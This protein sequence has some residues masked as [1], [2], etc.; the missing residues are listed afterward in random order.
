MVV[1]YRADQV[2]S[3]LRP[4][5]V[6]EARAAYAEGRVELAQLREA[7][8]RAILDALEMQRQIGID[9]FTDGEM[10]RDAWMSTLADAVD[11]FIDEY[12]IRHWHKLDGS[13]ENEPSRAKI[14]AGKLRQVRRL[15]AHDASFL[16]QH[17]PGPFKITM[18]SPVT[19]SY[20]GYQA[21]VTDKVYPTREQL[22][23]T[24]VPI[25][26]SELQA[27]AREGVSYI[28][29]DEGFSGYVGEAWRGQLE[30]LGLEPAK[31]LEADIAAENACYDALPRDRIVLGIHICRGNSK[32]RWGRIGGYDWLAEQVFSSLNVDRFLL[33]Y[34]SDRAG[35]FEPLRF[36]PKGKI[37]VLG[38]VTTKHGQPEP[39]DE[40][41]RQIDRA[42]KYLPLDQL[43][44]SPQCGFASVSEGNLLSVDDQHRKLEL[45]VD[46]ARKVWG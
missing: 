22:L 27:L 23:D 41:M 1:P 8:D 29:L 43:A 12:Q 18:P 13:T 15:T 46:T 14:A 9:I 2:G 36:V 7:E 24:L 44:L 10:R 32:S 30:R 4:A 11:G 38:L 6:L 17:A 35:S 26:K 20:S 42:S 34:D 40:L 16:Q 25:I 45:V 31:V 39:Q 21:G 37:V 3:L 19:I 28:Q 33:E 5:E